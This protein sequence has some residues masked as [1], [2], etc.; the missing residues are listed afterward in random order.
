MVDHLRVV[1]RVRD[2][3]E[4]P[5]LKVPGGAVQTQRDGYEYY[6]LDLE[7]RQGVHVTHREQRDA[8]DQHTRGGVLGRGVS[9][10]LHHGSEE[11]GG[12]H[13]GRFG[14]YARGV[15]EVRERRVRGV[16]SPAG[17]RG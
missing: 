3:E 8:H 17:A 13:L 5:F 12:N 15:V 7:R 10:A 4:P 9:P 6:T 11:H 14:D 16:H 2:V 1:H